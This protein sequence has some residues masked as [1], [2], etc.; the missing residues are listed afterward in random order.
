MANLSTELT[1]ERA[2]KAI[3]YS[4]SN[5]D[6]LLEALTH[7]SYTNEMKVN[8]RNHY[9]RNEFLGDAVLELYSSEFLFHK[10]KD[11]PEGKLSKMRA[12]MVCEQSLAICARK[13]DLGNLIFFGKGEE[14]AGGREKDSILS[15]VVEAIL[16][17]IFLD[18]GTTPAKAYVNTHILEVLNSDDL[19]V[20]YK[21]RLQE[22]LQK[23]GHNE[24]PIYTVISE[25]GPEHDKTFEVS[26]SFEDRVLA[27]GS[28]RTKKSAS[29]DAALHA[30][31]SLVKD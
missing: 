20:D 21:T 30:V 22:W 13:M 12:S 3:G 17:A 27:I 19:F 11:A 29:Q 31:N 18:G 9:E 16:G 25:S 5:K 26:V 6:V 2:E 23:Q 15:D 8:K 24:T 7:S 1:V 4:F 14:A 10:F 28:G